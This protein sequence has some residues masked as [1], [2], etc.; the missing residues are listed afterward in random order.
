M[1]SFSKDNK[2]ASKVKM[3]TISSKYRP[4]KAKY[5]SKLDAERLRKLTESRKNNSTVAPINPAAISTSQRR[6]SEAV[7]VDDANEFLIGHTSFLSDMFKDIKCSECSE[8]GL[9]V[10]INE[11]K[12][13][14]VKLMV[15]CNLCET[16]VGNYYTSPKLE[17]KKNKLAAFLVNRKAVDSTN[18]IGNGYAALEKFCSNFSIRPMAQRTYQQH[19]NSISQESE[20][21]E[22]RFWKKR[23]NL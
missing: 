9:S 3:H 6:L 4:P 18:S 16:V 14:C 20:A 22:K 21:L 2:P 15:Y 8:K 10:D 19:L 11:R 17:T 12:G 1:I 5:R 23:V 13:L 7:N